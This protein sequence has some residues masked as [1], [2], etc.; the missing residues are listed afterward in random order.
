MSWNKLIDRIYTENDLARNIS[1][2]LSGVIALFVYLHKQ[3]AVLSL[4]SLV[5]AF[6][7]LRVLSGFVIDPIRKK[8]IERQL[9]KNERKAFE[10]L[11]YLE[12]EVVGEFVSE[13][14]SVLT[15]QLADQAQLDEAAVLSLIN[16]GVIK[17]RGS[18]GLVMDHAFFSDA[19]RH[20]DESGQLKDV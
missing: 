5:I 4:L 8:K 1:I 9:S 6:P 13:G 19:C 14:T 15:S 11:T 17:D 3:D 7:V 16:R 20:F 12:R 2:S 10:E 18:V